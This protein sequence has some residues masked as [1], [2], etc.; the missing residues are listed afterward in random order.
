MI[1]GGCPDG[2]GMGGPGY[3][4]KDEFLPGNRN[5]KG[6]ISMANAGPNSGGSQFF[7]NLVDN[8]HLDQGHPVFGKVINGLDIVMKIGSVR[9]DGGDKPVD[10]VKI[11][12]IEVK[13]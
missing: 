4:I 11:E 5:S 1:Q 10:D 13:E 2:N 7:I 8:N 12:K 9:V 6:T 3:N